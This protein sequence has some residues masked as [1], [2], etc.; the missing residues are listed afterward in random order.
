MKKFDTFFEGFSTNFHFIRPEWLWALIP[1][2]LLFIISWVS[3]RESDNWKKL[4]NPKL[5]PLLLIK[6]NK[7]GSWLPKMLMIVS[8]SLIVICIAGPSWKRVDKPGNQTEAKVVVILDLSRSMLAKDIGP[9][10]L[11]RAKM[12]IKDY[13]KINK[14]VE[15]S[16]IVFAGTAHEA[17][18][19]TKDYKTFE[20][21]LE[22]LSPYSMPLYGS[23]L[24]EALKL[25]DKIISKTEAPCFVWVLTDDIQA[26]DVQSLG[27]R[28]A[29]KDTYSL[30]ILGTPQGANVPLYGNRLL[31]DKKGKLVKVALNTT[32]LQN[33]LAIP[34]VN[35]LPFTLDKT[36][37]ELFTKNIQDNLV[38][39]KDSKKAEEDWV[40][41][42]YYI[43]FLAAFLML[44][45]FRKG[46]LIQWTWI[47]LLPFF[48][49]SCD[50]IDQLPND[51]IT[52]EDLF[53]TRDQQAQ[54][55]LEK[56]DT[57]AAAS[58]FKDKSQAGYA[59]SISGDYEKAADAYAQDITAD[60]MYNL[61]VSQ[62][63][64]GNW[65]AAQ[66]AFQMALDINPEFKQAEKNLSIA[67]EQMRMINI[68]MSDESNINK[69]KVMKGKKYEPEAGEEEQKS[70]QHSD[71]KAE[72]ESEKIQEMGEKEVNPSMEELLKMQFSETKEQSK[73]SMIR[74]VKLDPKMYLK[75]KFLYQY[76]TDEDQPK[77]SDKSW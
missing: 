12:K 73:A 65:E 24:P 37:I 50:S 58:T 75:K 70:A 74:Q 18:P 7:K 66:K 22:A 31:K 45:W 56:G 17:L 9:S 38:F 62:A 5:L 8:L 67:K 51:N 2:G 6:G 59:Y 40:D 34:N 28:G 48:F 49:I 64:L 23:N 47:L 55:K 76:L 77:K 29:T 57:L 27:Q 4:V 14:G 54:K 53:W 42:G 43:S 72:G 25:S 46:L 60:N 19:P 36:D 68:N 11:E 20:T 71:R 26:I 3:I 33:A 16:L 10:R 63:K 21:T 44:F 1:I 61:G 13:L 69:D 41:F 32:Q 15:T 39:T 52:V 35:L 30:T